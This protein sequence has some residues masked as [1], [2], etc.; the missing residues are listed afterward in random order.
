LE[1]IEMTTATF[2][3]ARFDELTAKVEYSATFVPFSRS[4]NRDEKQCNLNWVITLKAGRTEFSTDYS[5]GVGHIPK[6]QHG[7]KLVIYRDAVAETCETGLNHTID[8]KNDMYRR[9]R[10][11]PL[12]PPAKADVFYCLLMDSDVVY[13]ACFEDWASELGHDTDSRKAAKVY[14]ACLQTALKFRRFF[15]EAE[16]TELRD[17]FSDY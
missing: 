5:Q 9:L 4:R 16:L 7:N 17:L 1:I 13:F 3:Q 12:A 14:E 10:A 2:N 15:N 8:Y 11:K 6:Y